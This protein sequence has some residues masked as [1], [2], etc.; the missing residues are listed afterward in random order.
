[1][2]KSINPYN[3]EVVYE[4][5]AMSTEEV[6]SFVEKAH[7]AY[8]SWRKIGFPER[9]LLM[10]RLADVLEDNKER[11]A[12][13]MTKEMGKPISQ[14]VA[15]VEKCAWVCR[16]YAENGE[17]QLAKRDIKTDA[18]ESY[19]RYDPLGVILGVMPWNYPFWQVFRFAVPTLYAG[20]TVLLKHA[21]NVM[22][23]SKMIQDVFD[24]AGF[25]PHTFTA[26]FIGSK[27]VEKVIRNKYVQGV[28]LTGSK[29]AGSAVASVASEEI[30]PSL[31]ELG[32]N[33]A[34]VVFE[35]CNLE[36]SVDIVL[37]ARF[38]NTGQSCIAGKRLLLQDKIAEE[39]LDRLT[40]K[41]KALKAGDPMDKE[42]YVG[43]MVN[44]EAANTL[45]EQ[46]N[47]SVKMGAEIVIGGNHDGAY[48]EPT[49][50]KNVSNDMPV[51]QEETFGPLLAVATFYS[52]EEAIKM[53]NE[54]EFGL[55]VSIFTSDS[56]RTK[57]LIPA[58]EDGAVFVNDLV[59]SDP[60]LPFGGTKISG[61]GR[62]L[63]KDG[64]LSFVNV[65]TVYIK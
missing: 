34:L 2:I 10:N 12:K 27:E 14:A 26:L 1:M 63:S 65:K 3:D 36:E 9:S 56:E 13:V 54:S 41:V 21:S 6:E 17:S 15:E 4:N 8:N 52:E 19:V 5:Q 39:F 49:I 58:F 53:V 22:E 37:Q 61:Y 43:V 44:E 46:L 45:Q 64:I 50:V 62:E 55:G 23:S 31:L 28:S 47:K 7:N 33:N 20:N 11:Y 42:T 40:K 57:R 25:P 30:K 60:R 38:Q 18:K 51:Y 35:D 32:G 29:P 16:Y 59:K 24:K 48:F